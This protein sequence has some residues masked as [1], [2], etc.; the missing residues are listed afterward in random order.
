LPQP[1]L[2]RREKGTHFRTDWTNPTLVRHYTL[3][4]GGRWFESSHPDL[5]NLLLA[6]HLPFVP[7]S[8]PSSFLPRIW[9]GRQ[10]GVSFSRLNA[11]A[12][13]VNQ[14]LDDPRSL[15][16]VVFIDLGV[17]LLVGGYAG[18]AHQLFDDVHRQVV[19]PVLAAGLTQR[20]D[21]QLAY[22]FYAS[23]LTVPLELPQDIIDHMPVEPGFAVISLQ[24]TAVSKMVL[25]SFNYRSPFFR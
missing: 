20:V 13:T 10:W 4:A 1:P 3:G 17:E 7:S 24:S 6:K 25:H 15:G 8:V 16:L 11:F 14:L 21:G 9:L 22:S 5:R 12:N 23:L 2:A 19:C 18:V